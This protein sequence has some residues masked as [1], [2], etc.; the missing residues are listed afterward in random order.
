MSGM[1]IFLIFVGAIF[2]LLLV[3][4]IIFLMKKYVP[5]VITKVKKRRLEDSDR[6][7]G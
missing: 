3:I 4:D 5:K 6:E 7:G 2:T 1:N